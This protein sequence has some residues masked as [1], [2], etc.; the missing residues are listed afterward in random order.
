M[1]KISTLFAA[2]A[3]MAIPA[4]AQWQPSDTDYK[5][6]AQ[7]SLYGQGSLKT[8]RTANGKTV[9]TWT[10]HSVGLKS[11]NPAS[12]YHLYMQTYD[13]AGNALFGNEGKEIL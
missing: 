7:D 10:K 1:K 5:I 3:F 9:L 12:G 2:L 13:A 6:V 4:S 11:T 8:L